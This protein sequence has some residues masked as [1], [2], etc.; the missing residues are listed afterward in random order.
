M[1]GGR[2]TRRQ[3]ALERW[4]TSNSLTERKG[5]SLTDDRS[6][7]LGCVARPSTTRLEE[8]PAR[9][10][11]VR[12]RGAKPRPVRK[13]V[14]LR[15]L[16]SVWAR[17]QRSTSTV[18]TNAFRSTQK[19]SSLSLYDVCVTVRNS[20]CTSCVRAPTMKGPFEPG[21]PDRK[22]V[23]SFSSRGRHAGRNTSK[24]VPQQRPR[25]MKID[26][27]SLGAAHRCLADDRRR[28]ILDY[29]EETDDRTVRFDDLV[30]YVAERETHSPAP[31][32]KNVA[33]SLHH[34]HLP[35]LA[36]HGI[37]DYDARTNTISR[38]V[39]PQIEEWQALA[40]Q[41]D[42]VDWSGNDKKQ[43]KSS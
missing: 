22:T 36:E 30:D 10:A 33:A 4:F 7:R 17:S 15:R 34:V 40:R 3:P 14:S 37:F 2:S 27:S 20:D 8:K 25:P 41:I 28:T 5:V 32:R 31:D 12:R 43:Q 35:M 11:G 39:R 42:E 13:P 26:H 6:V 29:L 9:S 21:H 23:S 19:T 38:L 1:S 16:W 24:R 18:T